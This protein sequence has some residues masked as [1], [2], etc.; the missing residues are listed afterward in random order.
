[1]ANSNDNRIWED[2][3]AYRQQVS[4]AAVQA[5]ALSGDDLAL[6]LAYEV[7][8]FSKIPAP[9][10]QVAWREIEA[11]DKALRTFEV[12]V[13]RRGGAGAKS[14]NRAF[15]NLL[16]AAPAVL[17]ALALACDALIINSQL[18]ENDKMLAT[19]RPLDAQIRRV[20]RQTLDARNAADAIRSKREAFAAAQT[21]SA[22]LRSAYLEIMDA[23]AE[24]CAGRIV[25][26]EFAS[27][28]PFSL[29]MTSI[30][31]DAQQAAD[32]M[33]FLA[34]AASSRSWRLEPGEIAAS[35]KGTT[36]SFTCTLARLGTEGAK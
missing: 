23:I 18:K 12:A 14:A 1:M 11:A 28:A 31:G 33:A 3:K 27:T 4:L 5:A 36:A 2:P 9:E 20:E 7:E 25:V 8:P 34:S 32:A 29:S 19:R 15:S 10:A 24:T 22:E 6:A 21:R 16:L 30:A 26:K 13:V 17:I 35:A